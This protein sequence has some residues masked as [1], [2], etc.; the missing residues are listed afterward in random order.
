MTNGYR[1]IG[2]D[3]ARK[4]ARDIV[5]GK[6]RFFDDIKIPG[7]LYGK[8]KRSPMPTPIS[9]ASIPIGPAACPACVPS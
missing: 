2:K 8:V 6:A 9:P 5:T 7:M 1:Y 4:D 3:T